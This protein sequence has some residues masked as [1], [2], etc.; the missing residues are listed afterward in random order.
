[1][2]SFTG[3]RPERENMARGSR[4]GR[5]VQPARAAT[6]PGVVAETPAAGSA[7]DAVDVFMGEAHVQTYTKMTEIH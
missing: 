3:S 2:A 5:C 6:R 1:M 7:G 4:Q